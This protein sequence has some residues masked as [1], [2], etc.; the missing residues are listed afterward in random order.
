MKI[1]EFKILIFRN[2]PSPFKEFYRDYYF[3]QGHLSDFIQQIKQMLGG[4]KK[5]KYDLLPLSKGC[6]RALES[7]LLYDRDTGSVNSWKLK[8]GKTFF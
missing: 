8:I 5:P 7:K 2:P 1:R 6:Q 4:D 3:D